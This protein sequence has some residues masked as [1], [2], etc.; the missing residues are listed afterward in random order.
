MIDRAALEQLR[1]LLL[2]VDAVGCI[3]DA[4]G[5]LDGIAGRMAEE[6]VGSHAFDFVSP[7]DH[8]LLAQIFLPPPEGVPINRRGV[9]FELTLIAPDGRHEHVDV[10]PTAFDHDGERRWIVSVTPKRLRSPAH[11][12]MDVVIDGGDLGAVAD[13]LV[14]DWLMVGRDDPDQARTETFVVMDAGTADAEVVSTG[15]H[16]AV[17]RALLDP[18]T[19]DTFV[20]HHQDGVIHS[21]L[22][23]ELGGPFAEACARA[24]FPAAHVGAADSRDGVRWWV[25]WLIDDAAFA[26]KL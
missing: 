15:A 13:R 10:L 3:L 21:T 9:P 6:F 1:C 5:G 11:R 8:E 16:P 4:N 14:S 7:A 18:S 12:L 22:I 23:D 17:D 20:R 24:G 19:H 26:L 2:E 25:V